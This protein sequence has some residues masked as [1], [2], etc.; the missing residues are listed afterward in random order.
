VGHVEL[1]SR[2]SHAAPLHDRDEDVQI[3]HSQAPTDPLS[4][5]IVVLDM[6]KKLQGATK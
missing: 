5:S 6:K 4:Q 1:L 2:L 3:W